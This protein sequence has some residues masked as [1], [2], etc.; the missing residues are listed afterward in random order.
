[1]EENQ[2]CPPWT[3]PAPVSQSS[4]ASPAPASAPPLTTAPA[5]AVPSAPA[6]AVASAPARPVAPTPTQAVASAPA[7]RFSRVMFK[8]AILLVKVERLLTFCY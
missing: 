8:L 6:H 7:P 5:H 1:M 3:F 4:V 2:I